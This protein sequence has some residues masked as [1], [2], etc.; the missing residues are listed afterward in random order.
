MAVGVVVEE[1]EDSAGG[2]DPGLHEEKVEDSV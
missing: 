1:E 2:I